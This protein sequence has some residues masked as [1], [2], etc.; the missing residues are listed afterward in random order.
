MRTSLTGVTFSSRR[1]AARCVL[2]SSPSASAANAERAVVSM[3]IAA[4]STYDTAASA[5]RPAPAAPVRAA[6]R[7]RATALSAA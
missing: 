2:S 5:C 7:A 4:P 1:N 3:R 6:A